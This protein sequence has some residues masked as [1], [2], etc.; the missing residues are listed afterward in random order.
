VAQSSLERV[1]N[2]KVNSHLVQVMLENDELHGN[3]NKAAIRGGVDEELTP[4]FMVDALPRM[5][6]KVAS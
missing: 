3:V 5:A 2:G 1:A 6:S 4:V